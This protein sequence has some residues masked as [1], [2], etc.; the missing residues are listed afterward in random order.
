MLQLDAICQTITDLA[1]GV[2]EAFAQ[3]PEAAII[4]SFPGL[5]TIS[6]ARVLAEIGDDAARF[7]SARSLK[8][9]AGSAPVTRVSG[10]SRAVSARVVKNQR[11]AG[12]GYM[13]AFA[14]LRTPGPRE[15]YKQRRA[16]RRATHVSPAPPFQSPTRLSLP[17]S[18]DAPIL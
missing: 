7:A 9:Y 13:W 10:R 15:H 5:S 18:S 4:T 14:A 2:E 17:L 3:Y 6:G 12:P 11:L 16:G 8:A 1:E